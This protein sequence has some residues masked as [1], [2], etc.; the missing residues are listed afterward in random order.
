MS[1]IQNG[2]H[3]LRLV[4]HI[5]DCDANPVCPNG[6]EVEEHQKCGQW[7]FDSKKTK[8]YLSLTQDI[9]RAIEGHE[10]REELA[11]K[12][13]LNANVLDY[14]LKHPELIPEE[15]KGKLIF[16]WGTIYRRS[17]GDLIVRYLGRYRSPEWD[18]FCLGLDDVFLDSDY[19]VL[20]LC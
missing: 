10:L 6:W 5:I 4:K 15:W 12:S 2:T 9:G 14:L 13:V 20:R 19:A 17:V 18:W 7:E 3:E 1:F 8:L 11:D 16:F